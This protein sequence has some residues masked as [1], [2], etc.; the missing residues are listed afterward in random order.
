MKTVN[1]Q[2]DGN[3]I[4]G[5]VHGVWISILLWCLIVAVMNFIKGILK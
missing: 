3:A 1:D 5:L 4:E 2:T